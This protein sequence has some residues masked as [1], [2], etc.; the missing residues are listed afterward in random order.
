MKIIRHCEWFLSRKNAAH[1]SLRGVKH[2]E[3]IHNHKKPHHFKKSQKRKK[4]VI[5]SERTARSVAIHKKFA[6]K[7]TPFKIK[8][9]T[10]KLENHFK[11]TFKGSKFKIRKNT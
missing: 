11:F 8:I 10:Q 2:A 9:H 1:S 5:A 6:R 3:A 7:F 4:P